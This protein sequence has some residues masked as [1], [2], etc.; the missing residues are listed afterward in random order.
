MDCYFCSTCG[1]RVMHR[2]RNA[3]GSTRPTVSVK[4]GLVDGLD[5]SQG[6]HIFTGTAVV[7]IPEGVERWEGTPNLS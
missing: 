3:D 4:G 5:W 1:V 2:T 6:K 7:P